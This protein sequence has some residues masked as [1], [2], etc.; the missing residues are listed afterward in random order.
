MGVCNFAAERFVPD[1]FDELPI[2]T[3]PIYATASP[4]QDIKLC[5]GSA[6]IWSSFGRET[7][8]DCTL[9]L[10]WLPEPTVRFD[11]DLAPN[12]AAVFGLTA[13]RGDDP[14]QL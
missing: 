10:C 2:A 3:A 9:K 11:F 6:K 14:V 7:I 4:N 5:S 8:G 1:S 13:K 12:E